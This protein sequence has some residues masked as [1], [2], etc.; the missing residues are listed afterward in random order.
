MGLMV[1][2]GYLL[3][4]MW[5]QSLG[6]PSSM[7]D[8]CNVVVMG[9]TLALV[10][11]WD[12]SRG[13]ESVLRIFVAF[14][15]FSRWYKVA[16]VFC[17]IESVGISVL[18]IL[19]AI[20]DVARIAPFCWVLLCCFCA[21]AH[22]FYVLDVLLPVLSAYSNAVLGD[23][24]APEDGTAASSSLSD[25]LRLAFLAVG[26]VAV[27]ALGTILVAIV[28]GSY[29][30][31]SGNAYGVFLRHRARAGANCA[32]FLRA[33]RGLRELRRSPS[34]Q[35][36]AV[37]SANTPVE[38]G[39]YVWYSRRRSSLEAATAFTVE[40]P[41][42]VHAELDRLRFELAQHRNEFVR[43][44][45]AVSRHLQ[46]TSQQH[47]WHQ[48]EQLRMQQLQHGQALPEGVVTGNRRRSIGSFATTARVRR[49][50][51]H[52]QTRRPWPTTN[53]AP[54]SQ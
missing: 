15:A 45:N 31:A 13:L 19:V 7:L 26:I 14:A 35:A 25:S 48:Q 47:Q 54:L 22:S 49:H 3:E 2:V 8:A 4:E 39:N 6:V 20:E 43:G 32:A 27:A 18:P 42:V 30:Q 33:W 16:H 21:A 28:G 52:Q 40:P 23:R 10:A 50:A 38:D 12:G 5:V 34:Q 53:T 36:L 9:C 17:T 29:K 41:A 1:A 11:L 46:V 37:P 24:V 44:L 51:T